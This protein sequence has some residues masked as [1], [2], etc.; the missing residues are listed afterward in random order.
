MA[1]KAAVLDA[2]VRR[3]APALAVRTRGDATKR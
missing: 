3:S 1:L 2:R